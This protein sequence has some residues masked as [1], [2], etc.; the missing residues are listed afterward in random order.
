MLYFLQN[1][2]EV[3]ETIR[4][5]ARSWGF[6]QDEF[7]DSGH[8][9]AELYVREGRR[10]IGQYVFTEND[11]NHAPGDARS[12]LHTDAIAMGDYGPNCHGTDHE[13]PR[14]GGKH[15][16]EFYKGVPPYQIPYGS[17]IPKECQNLLVPVA[18]SSSHVGF[19]A[20]RLE[21][22]W[23]SLGQAAGV[24]AGIAV[25]EQIPVQQVEAR[26]IQQRLHQLQAATLYVSDVLPGHPDFA[27]VQWWGTL[28]GLHGVNPAPA[29]PGQRGKNILGQ[30]YE[31]YPGHTAQLELTL[32]PEL[33]A[34]W[35]QIAHD[36]GLT[37]TATPETTRGD[38]IRSVWQQH[39]QQASWKK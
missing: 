38:F 5:E 2:A 25:Q 37:T 12:V 11:T 23:T 4:T 14:F 19:C 10:L 33:L 36:A 18:C 35:Q 6:C 9:P 3:P 20:L 39:S 26:K 21:P 15:I 22:I 13:G 31:A 1:D 28:G 27:A 30:Y 8:I 29:K 34:H 17:L 16:G 24:A 7:T 32:T